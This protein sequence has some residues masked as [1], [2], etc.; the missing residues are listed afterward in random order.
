MTTG[1]NTG[2]GAIGPTPAPDL[3][4]PPFARWA[5]LRGIIERLRAEN[6]DVTGSLVGTFEAPVVVELDAGVELVQ[7]EDDDGA[8]Y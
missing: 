8:D 3:S 4:Y 6:W 1:G 7:V 2:G 5:G